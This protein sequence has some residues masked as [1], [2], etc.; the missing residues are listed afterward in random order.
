MPKG[1]SQ[2]DAHL[3]ERPEGD[4]R[5]LQVS[6]PDL[7]AQQRYGADNSVHDHTAHRGQPKDQT[8]RAGLGKADS[9]TKLV[10]GLKHMS[11]EEGLR[12]LGLFSL[13]GEEAQG[14]HYPTL[15]LAE[16]RL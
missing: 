14:Q 9:S 6:Q 13:P 16:R 4:S 15:Q 3:Q 2:C 7:S 8:L 11:Y 5:E 12:E 10:D 1:A